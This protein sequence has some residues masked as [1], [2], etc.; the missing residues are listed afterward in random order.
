MTEAKRITTERSTLHKMFGIYCRAH[1]HTVEALC[2]E[3]NSLYGYAMEKIDR[4]VFGQ[5]KPTCQ[6]CPVH[7]YSQEKRETIKIIM[8]YVGPKMIYIHPFL[9]VNHF[10][11]K[12]ADKKKI[13]MLMEIIKKK[14]K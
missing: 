1:H 13:P 4:C 5:D 14:S 10:V 2:D 8:R 3:C 12:A 11:N 6:N 7:C 9:A